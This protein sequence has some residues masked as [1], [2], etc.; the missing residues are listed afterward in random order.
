MLYTGITRAK[1]DIKFIN[2]NPKRLPN[3]DDVETFKILDKIIY[4]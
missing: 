2:F 1:E 4:P 3:K